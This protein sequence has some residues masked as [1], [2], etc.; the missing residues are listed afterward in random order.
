MMNTATRR[1]LARILFIAGP[2]V[3]LTVTPWMSYDPINI[4]KLAVL[5]AC[6]GI[7][8]ALLLVDFRILLTSPY[9]STV[10]VSALFKIDLLI[11]LLISPGPFNQQ[12]FGTF[13]RNTGYLAYASLLILFIAAVV[14]LDKSSTERL[15][16]TLFGVGVTSTVYGLAQSLGWD[17]IHWNN[18]YAPVIGFLG[19]PDFESSFL[20][21]CG[22]VAVAF[23]LKRKSSWIS[24][25]ILIS[26]LLL[27]LYVMSKT[28]AVQG[29]LVL[30]VG[31]AVVLYL[32][33]HSHKRLKLFSIPYLLLS[34]V[35]GIFV[36]IGSLNKGPLAHYLY[37]LSVT[38][39][40]D[41][42]RAG[43]KMTTDHPFTG[44]GLDSYGDWYRVSRTLAATLRRGPDITSNAAHN[45]FLDFSS[46][47]G[48]PLLIAYLLILGLTFVSAIRVIRRTQGFDV[49]HA[50]L[51]GA[52]AAYLAQ[53]SI[54]L[55][56]LG[57]AVWGWILSGALIAY[58]I[59][60][61]VIDETPITPHR[62]KIKKGRNVKM[63][64]GTPVATMAIFIGLI[65]G[66]ALGLPPFLADAKYRSSLTISTAT[67]I[68]SAVTAWPID[69]NRL[70][71]SSILMKNSKLEPQA[72]LLAKHAAK[73]NPR[74]Y[75]SW[76]LINTSTTSTAAEK[77]AALVRM[78]LLDPHNP[79]LK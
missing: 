35:T 11:V 23:L 62:T 79:G 58:E 7:A 71:Q 34:V 29:F 5:L 16:W 10:L 26:Y 19:N 24:R 38:Y 70:V 55:N 45:V 54:S 31:V 48:F 17:P 33:I 39:R 40:G 59:H 57:L 72:L 6:A 46:N 14:G 63:D 60:T 25:G 43:W 41:Y 56:Q 74:L 65:V 9:R 67:A 69:G 12:F 42:W 44:V 76:K 27:A 32:Y 49:V 30:A 15:L 66:L 22:V 77:A 2:V 13:G 28:K 8:L 37:K 47:G 36:V 50:A 3:T 20:G 4:P 61:R 78:K 18:P 1:Q 68:E 75:D 64:R 51:F 53:S 52:W 73:Y 21:I